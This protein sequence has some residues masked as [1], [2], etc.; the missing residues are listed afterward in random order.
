MKRSEE[1]TVLVVDD[2]PRIRRS[3]RLL[4]EQAG[5]HVLEAGRG[6]AAVELARDRN[7]DCILLDVVL[8]DT[9]GFRVVETLRRFSDVPILML[10][11]RDAEDD[12]VRGFE[13][14]ADDYVVKPFSGRELVARVRANLRRAASR[15]APPGRQ[16][17]THGLAIDFASRRV[18]VHSKPVDLTP[19][20]FGL[21][22]EL[23]THAGSVLLPADLLRAVWGPSYA[24]DVGLLRTAVWRLRRKIEPEAG[25]PRF[26]VT[27]NRVGYTFGVTPHAPPGHSPGH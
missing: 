6:G 19:T 4:L 15:P 20:E 24:D 22:A 23:A 11:G 18:E 7:P 3:V 21:L 27:V 25:S 9:D 10:T 5:W 26:I 16:T 1:I 13:A 12:R 14:G 2:E 8:P 17:Y